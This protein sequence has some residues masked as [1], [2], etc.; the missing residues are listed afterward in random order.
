[1]MNWYQTIKFNEIFP[2]FLILFQ[3]GAI[4]GIFF[5]FMQR[6]IKIFNF[7]AILITN[8]ILFILINNS[9]IYNTRFLPFVIMSYI[10]IGAIGIGEILDE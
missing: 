6:N 3:V 2:K 8:F 7:L 9:P 10:L 4:L 1:M 5:S